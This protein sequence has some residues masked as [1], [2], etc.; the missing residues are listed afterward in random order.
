MQNVGE[1][2]QKIFR[3]SPCTG[4]FSLGEKVESKNDTGIVIKF[5]KQNKK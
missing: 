4:V 2:E 5:Y 3:Q 1:I